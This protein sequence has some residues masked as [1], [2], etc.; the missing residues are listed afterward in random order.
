M[1]WAASSRT[2]DFAPSESVRA[3]REAISAFSSSV[4]FFLAT[5]SATSGVISSGEMLTGSAIS[6]PTLLQRKSSSPGTV[7]LLGGLAQAG[8]VLLQL[9]AVLRVQLAPPGRQRGH[10]LHGGIA[11]GLQLRV[12]L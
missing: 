12:F 5:T 4:R 11:P 8:E 1:A 3:F 2:W 9:A 6:L 7:G 10:P